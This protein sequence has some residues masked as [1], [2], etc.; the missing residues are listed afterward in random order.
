[1]ARH[2]Q[3]ELGTARGLRPYWKSCD[4]PNEEGSFLHGSF[5]CCLKAQDLRGQSVVIVSLRLCS[6]IEFAAAHFVS[7]FLNVSSQEFLSELGRFLSVIACSNNKQFPGVFP[8]LSYL[9]HP[10]PESL[11]AVYPEIFGFCSLNH[12]YVPAPSLSPMVSL[13]VKLRPFPG[14]TLQMK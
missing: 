1:M 8:H 14:L 10:P 12:I 11:F 4:Y 2:S 3:P 7:F 5:F 6:M 13:R 9:P